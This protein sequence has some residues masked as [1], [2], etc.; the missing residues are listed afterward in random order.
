MLMPVESGAADPSAAP[1]A[2]NLRIARHVRGG[3]WTE[4]QVAAPGDTPA[5]KDF[6]HWRDDSV[7]LSLEA[8]TLLHEPFARA[9]PGFDLFLPRLFGPEALAKLATELEAFAKRSSGPINET[10]I[11]LSALARSS[12]AKGQSLWVLGP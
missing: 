9:L 4:I 12:A 11:E 5:R 6:Q 3:A 7:F 8:I 1:A 10:A 2:G